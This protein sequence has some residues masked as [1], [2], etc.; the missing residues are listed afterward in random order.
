MK[1]EVWTSTGGTKTFKMEHEA[2]AYVQKV[3]GE[4]SYC[5]RMTGIRVDRDEEMVWSWYWVGEDG[6]G[7]VTEVPDG[8][9]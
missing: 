1:Y 9:C 7:E 4:G 8:V 5:E 6:V 3:L 2:M